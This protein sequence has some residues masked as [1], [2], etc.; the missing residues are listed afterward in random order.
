MSE[1]IH[2]YLNC[3]IFAQ[4]G[5]IIIKPTC[6]NQK[7]YD[8]IKKLLEEKGLSV[9]LDNAHLNDYK[10]YNLQPFDYKPIQEPIKQPQ[11]GLRMK[12]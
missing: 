5:K 7:E 4:D 12:A 11:K 9:W 8:N 2:L 6:N 3:H 1:N 10:K